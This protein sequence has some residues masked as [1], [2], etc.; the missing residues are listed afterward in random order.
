MTEDTYR[1]YAV[2]YNQPGSSIKYEITIQDPGGIIGHTQAETAADVELMVRD[3]L[4]TMGRNGDSQLE[5][6]WPH[7][8]H[9][10]GDPHP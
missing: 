9:D 8:D 2:P 10:N 4:N 6:R 3:W 7:P 1:A 5:I